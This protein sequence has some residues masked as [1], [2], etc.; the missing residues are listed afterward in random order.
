MQ[1]QK[2][3]DL[4]SALKDDGKCNTEITRHVVN[5]KDAFQNLSKVLI[6]R[7]ISLVILSCHLL[8]E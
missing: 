7:K 3:N 1:D 2:F 5:A 4:G 6:Y 8:L